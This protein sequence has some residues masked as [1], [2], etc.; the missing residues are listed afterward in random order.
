MGVEIAGSGITPP[1]V[2]RAFRQA[3]DVRFRAGVVEAEGE[4]RR[5]APVRTGYLRRSITHAVTRVASMLVGVIGTATR[6]APFLEFGTGLYG[7]RN[8][9]IVPTNAQALRFQAGGRASL[10]AGGARAGGSAGP[11][12][13][14]SGQQRS[15]AAGAG[16]Q[17]VF[18][19]SVRGIM[20]RRFFADGILISRGRVMAQLRMIAPDAMRL[21]S[22]GRVR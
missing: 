9:R 8:R 3:A 5:R 2:D 1:M 15:G 17:F 18:A 19:R 21:L 20:P 13:R 11:G 10:F 4:I 7:P 14:L 6:Y 16:A 22:S 12:F